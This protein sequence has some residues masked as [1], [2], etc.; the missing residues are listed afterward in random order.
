MRVF[1]INLMRVFVHVCIL[2][3]VFV[4]AYVCLCVVCVCV[5]VQ[6]TTWMLTLCL[7]AK[8]KRCRVS[9]LHLQ[10]VEDEAGARVLGPCL[11][12]VVVA[13]MVRQGGMLAYG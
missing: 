5:C 13:L 10:S 3:H 1:V 7:I 6:K 4:H 2:M 9:E 11:P 12:R 8:Q